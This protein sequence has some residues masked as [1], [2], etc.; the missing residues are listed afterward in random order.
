MIFCFLSRL[1]VAPAPATSVILTTYHDFGLLWWV[2]CPVCP[3]QSRDITS[4]AWS[5]TCGGGRW[6]GLGG[7][8]GG[9]GGGWGGFGRLVAWVQ[10]L[11]GPAK[12]AASLRQFTVPVMPPYFADRPETLC[13][14]E[15]LGFGLRLLSREPTMTT[16]GPEARLATC[17]TRAP[18][19]CPATALA[20]GRWDAAP[21]SMTV[22]TR[23]CGALPVLVTW[24]PRLARPLPT[25]LAF[26]VAPEPLSTVTSTCDGL[27]ELARTD[28]GPP[29]VDFGAVLGSLASCAIA[30]NSLWSCGWAN[31]TQFRLGG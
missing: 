29:V 4:L 23:L 28:G 2:I 10:G 17:F 16:T 31:S 8:W 14:G 5:W 21:Y 27:A 24:K 20:F 7:G 15:C 1:P 19:I 3:T 25:W 9:L 12:A 30:R 26:P 18:G 22:R 13:A 11:S 6:G